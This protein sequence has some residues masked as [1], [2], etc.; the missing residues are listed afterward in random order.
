L[1]RATSKIPAHR[2]VNQPHP[3]RL[4]RARLA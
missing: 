4:L 1:K 3:N 2:H